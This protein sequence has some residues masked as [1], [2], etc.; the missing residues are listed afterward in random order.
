MRTGFGYVA[1]RLSLYPDLSVLENLRFFGGA[2]RLAPAEVATRVEVLLDQMDLRAKREASAGSLSGGMKQMLIALTVAVAS[3]HFGVQFQ[4]P[5]VL[6]LICLLFL[7]CSLG[8][9]LLISSFCETQTQAIQFA[10][11]YLLSSFTAA[12]V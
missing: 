7:L 9:G 8:M 3:F 6:A 11:F 10:V 4:Q 1:Q 5:L 2:C 12:D